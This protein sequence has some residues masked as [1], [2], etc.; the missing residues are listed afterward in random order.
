M[1]TEIYREMHEQNENFKRRKYKYQTNHRAEK[2]NNLTKKLNL[3][4][5]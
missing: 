3:K 1:L 4:A 2:L 5:D